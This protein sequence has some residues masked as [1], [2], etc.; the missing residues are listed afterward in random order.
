MAVVRA[1]G[2]YVSGSDEDTSANKIDPLAKSL[3]I[4]EEIENVGLLRIATKKP[5]SHTLRFLQKT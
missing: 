3:D 4:A 1:N 2:Q 5:K